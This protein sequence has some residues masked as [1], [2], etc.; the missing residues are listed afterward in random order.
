MTGKLDDLMTATAIMDL[1]LR[2][3]ADMP[4]GALDA[5]QHGMVDD[6][7]V[8]IRRV[9]EDTRARRDAEARRRRVL[10]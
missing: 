7:E 6:V 1:V 3:L 4:P 2:E 5:E 10:I 8:L 9:Y